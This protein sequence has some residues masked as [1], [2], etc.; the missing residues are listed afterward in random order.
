[1]KTATQTKSAMTKQAVT[2]QKLEKPF[3]GQREKQ[4]ITDPVSSGR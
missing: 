3:S 2:S 4:G 1:M